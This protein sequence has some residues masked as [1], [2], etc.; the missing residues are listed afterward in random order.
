MAIFGHIAN[1]AINII[2][3]YVHTT[4]LQYVEFYSKFYEGGGTEFKP[5]SLK[6]QYYRLK[7]D[8]AANNQVIT[9]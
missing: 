9:D 8:I 3:A 7:D 4:R 6:T 2:G 5:L 1:L